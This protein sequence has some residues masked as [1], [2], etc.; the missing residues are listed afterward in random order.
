MR[1][2]QFSG[3][4]LCLV[5]FVEQSAL[6]DGLAQRFGQ[7]SAVL[8]WLAEYGLATIERGRLGLFAFGQQQIAQ[9]LGGLAEAGIGQI[10]QLAGSF[11]IEQFGNN[12]LSC[13]FD[14]FQFEYIASLYAGRQ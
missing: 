9:H 1:Q 11:R 7:F 13:L 8:W 6:L 5:S 12:G 3:D 4:P 2:W 14:D 10:G